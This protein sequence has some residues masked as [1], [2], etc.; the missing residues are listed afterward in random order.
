MFKPGDIV[1]LREDISPYWESQ[2]QKTTN[3]L[4][5]NIINDVNFQ[6]ELLNGAYSQNIKSL[7]VTDVT[8]DGL[9]YFRPR[10]LELV[11]LYGY[12]LELIERR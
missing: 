10:L 9:V 3:D 4:T 1:K 5:R 2:Q 6:S 7:V 11:C 12:R 8:T